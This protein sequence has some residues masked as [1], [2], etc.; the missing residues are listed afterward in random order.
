MARPWCVPDQGTTMADGRVRLT[1]RMIDAR[2][3][4][5]TG[6]RRVMNSEGPRFGV[7]GGSTGAVTYGLRFR[8]HGRA[9]KDAIGDV[10]SLSLEDARS[11]ARERLGMVA[12]GVA[13]VQ[14]RR[15]LAVAGITVR[16]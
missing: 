14:E 8:L 4:P 6:E 1:R 3:V 10:R 15:R 12:K 7:R 16:S 2:G 9:H 11:V 13:P 5:S